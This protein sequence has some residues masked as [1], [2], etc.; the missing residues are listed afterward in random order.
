MPQVSFRGPLNETDLGHERRRDPLHCRHFLHRHSGAPA[1]R[2]TAGKIRE[3]A[4]RLVK[5]HEP[6]E[7]LAK[8]IRDP[9]SISPTS[10]MP[11]YPLP[12]KDL[13]A[14][15]DFVLSLE[16]SEHGMKTVTRAQALGQ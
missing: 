7:Y 6:R 9:Q 13:E 14:L 8:Y 10:T 12:D 11:K 16:F 5:R 1:R 15:A 4:L 3:R 2:S